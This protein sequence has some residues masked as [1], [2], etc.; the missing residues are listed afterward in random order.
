VATSQQM[1][2]ILDIRTWTLQRVEV[3]QQ[4]S[5]ILTKH[6]S[7]LSPHLSPPSTLTLRVPVLCFVSARMPTFLIK[8]YLGGSGRGGRHFPYAICL[9]V[10]LSALSV[11][12]TWADRMTCPPLPPA[13]QE[14]YLRKWARYS[15]AALGVWVA[16][17]LLL[18]L[19]AAA[20]A[21]GPAH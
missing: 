11:G 5:R 1:D 6:H 9:S 19:L 14:E 4:A 2:C 13:V 21:P 15:L 8:L 18:G 3:E 12:R 10:L 17:A 7:E 16:L 20:Q